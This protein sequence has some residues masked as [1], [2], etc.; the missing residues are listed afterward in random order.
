MA[1]YPVEIQRCQ[2]IKTS[3]A[4]CGS[5]ALTDKEFC[6]YLRTMGAVEKPAGRASR[7][8]NSR[9][10]AGATNAGASWGIGHDCI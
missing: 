3:G 9:R 2:H 10:V 8:P 7:P 6:Y 5:P 4:Q 1:R